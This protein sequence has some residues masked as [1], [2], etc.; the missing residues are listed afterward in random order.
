MFI[1]HTVRC[2]QQCCDRTADTR[3]ATCSGGV[4]QRLA[5]VQTQGTGTQRGPEVWGLAVRAATAERC[6]LCRQCKGDSL[7][8]HI[9]VRG[10]CRRCVCMGV[11]ITG[12]LF[13]V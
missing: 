4:L 8:C 5:H 11:A 13:V 3:A 2:A 10:L 7:W 1:G 12:C 9:I 6:A